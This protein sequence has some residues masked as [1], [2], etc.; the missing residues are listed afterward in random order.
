MIELKLIWNSAWHV[1]N[2]MEGLGGRGIIIVV[3]I[4][5]LLLWHLWFLMECSPGSPAPASSP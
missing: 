1:V 3:I 2:A 4:F 5:L